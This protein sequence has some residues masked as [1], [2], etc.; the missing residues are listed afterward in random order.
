MRSRVSSNLQEILKAREE[1]WVYRRNL[2][3]KYR[4]PV[5]TITMNIPGPEKIKDEY[6]KAHKTLVKDFKAKGLPIIFEDYKLTSDGPEAY[7]VVDADAL[8]LKRLCISL[9]DEHPLGRIADIDLLDENKETISRKTLGKEERKCFLCNRPAT[10]CIVARR[11]SIHEL[12]EKV[13]EIIK[14]EK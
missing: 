1:R 14:G 11:H 3:E 8:D 9:E 6:I 12:L 2:A 5:V 13:D 7:M 4:K 10:S